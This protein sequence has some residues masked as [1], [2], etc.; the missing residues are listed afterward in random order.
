MEVENTPTAG[1]QTLAYGQ[2]PVAGQPPVMEERTFSGALFGFRRKDVLDYVR[3][4]SENNE[5]YIHTLGESIS[6]LQQELESSRVQAA[7]LETRVRELDAALE[8]G[9]AADT[10]RQEELER[11]RREY[12][13]C[14]EK[15]FGREQKYVQLQR[16]CNELRRRNEEIVREME[17]A[18]AVLQQQQQQLDEAAVR[19]A[20]R[21]EEHSREL[22]QAEQAAK[23]I[24]LQQREA[25]EKREAELRAEAQRRES[26][27]QQAH[28]DS[29]QRLK[30]EKQQELQRA[31]EE[32]Q[33]E[34]Q[35]V[36]EEKRQELQSAEAEKQQELQELGADAR[37]ILERLGARADAEQARL[38]RS[39]E[40]V[41]AELEELRA[42]MEQV[43][44]QIWA[45][46]AMIRQTTRDMD[47]LLRR[48]NAKVL[49]EGGFP[50]S[51]AHPAEAQ[52]GE[53]DPT[54][55]EGSAAPEVARAAKAVFEPETGE[56]TPEAQPAPVEPEKAVD[57]EPVLSG[58][59]QVTG[60]AQEAE[61][62][63]ASAP[64]THTVGDEAG[65]QESIS[66]QS[67]EKKGTSGTFHT[68]QYS[69]RVI[70]GSRTQTPHTTVRGA[71]ETV[72]EHLLDALSRLWDKR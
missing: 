69:Y 19:E 46:H 68:P 30:E 20:S 3:T 53:C 31:E 62:Q 24:L 72:A 29:L 18:R 44:Q 63:S 57:P 27:L 47:D 59:A 64:E 4:M 28:A 71:R 17:A 61:P 7:T 48:A 1:K 56:D 2:M 35:R 23:A 9:A 66:R 10:K 36:E 41:D 11:T 67:A 13:A 16:E 26:E 45:A 15:L 52:P 12:Q 58:F 22:T 38:A 60:A 40:R 49:Q 21:K 14:R 8:A 65:Q 6:A 51:A 34:L 25:A 33:Q 32:K 42:E 5:A 37:T 50:Y 70:P 39:V 43:Q 55:M 54:R